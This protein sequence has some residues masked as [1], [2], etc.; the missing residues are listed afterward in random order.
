[1][2]LAGDSASVSSYSNYIRILGRDMNFFTHTEPR[3]AEIHAAF[4][5]VS[6]RE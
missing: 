5:L 2:W 3:V 4:Y 6:A 1:M